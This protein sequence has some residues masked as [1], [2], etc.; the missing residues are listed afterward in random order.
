MKI[1]LQTLSYGTSWFY[2]FSAITLGLAI[3]YL[4][5]AA[6]Q[7]RARQE[8]LSRLVTERETELEQARRQLEETRRELETQNRN[9]DHAHQMLERFTYQD[10]LT[11]LANRRY[12]GGALDLE[13]RRTQRS[14]EYLSLLLI[15]VDQ[16]KTFNEVY[17]PGDGDECLRQIAKV[18]SDSVNRAGDLSARYSGK[19]FAVLL[20]ETD[21]EGASVVALEIQNRVRSLSITHGATRSGSVS[22]SIGVASAL[23]REGVFPDVLI[24]LAEDALRAAKSSG[25][26]RLVVS[27][28]VS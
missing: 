14:K 15:D 10:G 21:Q 8:E 18:L 28:K 16:F 1:D 26:D 13:W 11:G 17:G 5:R 27:E 4:F 25:G 24:D 19:Q 3:G 22:V 20:P 6:R 2:A 7:A 12:F 23:P 9:L